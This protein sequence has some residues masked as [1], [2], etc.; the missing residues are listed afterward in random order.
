[1][2]QILHTSANILHDCIHNNVLRMLQQ[3]LHLFVNSEYTKF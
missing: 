2:V 3:K 1:M